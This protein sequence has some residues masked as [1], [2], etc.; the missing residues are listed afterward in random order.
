M[1]DKLHMYAQA[2]RYLSEK[3]YWHVT[4]QLKVVIIE[5]SIVHVIRGRANLQQLHSAKHYKLD[6]WWFD[7]LFS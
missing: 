1:N 5:V 7:K 3:T 2:L 6:L 4:P